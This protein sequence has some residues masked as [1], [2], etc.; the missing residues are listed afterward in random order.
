MKIKPLDVAIVVGILYVL[1]RSNEKK[2][3]IVGSDEWLNNTAK[4][5]TQPQQG[6]G[7]WL[8]REEYRQ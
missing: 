5:V 8:L 4:S 3:P 2:Q 6:T 7:Y 1:M